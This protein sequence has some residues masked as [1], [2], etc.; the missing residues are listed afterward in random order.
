M[1]Q[2]GWLKRNRA[3]SLIL[4][5]AIVLLFAGGMDSVRFN[6]GYRLDMPGMDAGGTGGGSFAGSERA[7]ML[8]LWITLGA[9]VLS[10]FVSLLTAEGRQRLLLSSAIIATAFLL[11]GVISELMP[12]LEAPLAEQ[13][14]DEAQAEAGGAAG[15]LPP[16]G[17][18]GANPRPQ[19]QEAPPYLGYALAAV[20]SA[21]SAFVVFRSISSRARGAQRD[22]DAD[23]EVL[24]LEAWAKDA[25]QQ[26][27][28]QEVAWDAIQRSYFDLEQTARAQLGSVR[29]QHA[30]AREFCEVLVSYGLPR[31]ALYTLVDLF[32]RSR[33]GDTHAE[34]EQNERARSALS[35]IISAIEQ[36]GAKR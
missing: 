36:R 10:V 6:P 25:Q 8:V 35:T 32:E 27:E 28:E 20:L 12:E 14:E 26:L 11:L 9:S 21:L 5:A 34:D 3:M 24:S 19:P 17:D 29:H 18:T 4:M 7:F 1:K 13:V 22:P 23:D 15:D 16:T 33:Y 2:Y 30:T 31:D